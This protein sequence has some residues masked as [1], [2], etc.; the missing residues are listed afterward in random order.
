[1]REVG[2]VEVEEE[3]ERGAKL[4]SCEVDVEE[5]E[6]EGP[7]TVD[8]RVLRISSRV[9]SEEGICITSV[10]NTDQLL[11]SVSIATLRPLSQTQLTKPL[12]PYSLSNHSIPI[13]NISSSIPSPSFSN[14][15]SS[16][17]SIV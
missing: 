9:G 6:E 12:P 4:L 7:I 11:V 10:T 1:M 5:E 8:D 13:S 17:S 16:P 14:H 15:S 2:G 3:E